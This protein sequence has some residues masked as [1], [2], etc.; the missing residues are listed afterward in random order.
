MQGG[1][2]KHYRDEYIAKEVIIVFQLHCNKAMSAVIPSHNV[3][4]TIVLNLLN[5]NMEFSV[6]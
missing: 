1:V 3:K 5:T 6:S 2:T 4:V